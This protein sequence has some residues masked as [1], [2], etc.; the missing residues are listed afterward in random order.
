MTAEPTTVFKLLVAAV[1]SAPSAPFLIDAASGEER[2]YQTVLDSALAWAAWFS[3]HNVRE[4]IAVA[5]PNSAAFVE[6]SLGAALRGITLLAFNPALPPSELSAQLRH[7]RAERLFTTARH[8]PTLSD[9]PCPVVCV[10]ER[11]PQPLPPPLALG[12]LAPVAADTALTAV[13]TSGTSGHP[14]TALV[15]HR[16]A[17]WSALRTREAFG[18][19]PNTRYLTPLPLFHINAQ[20]VAVLTALAATSAVALSPRLPAAQLFEAVQ[21][22]RAQGLSL[23]P[24]LV[25]DLLRQEGSFGPLLRYAAGGMRR[26]RRA[27]RATTRALGS[28][29][30]GRRSR[31]HAGRRGSSG[32][33]RSAPD[34]HRCHQTS[35]SRRQCRGS[36]AGGRRRGR[37]GPGHDGSAQSAR[38]SSSAAD[39]EPSASGRAPTW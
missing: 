13:L 2:S 39:V 6:L 30:S 33:R 23:V 1:E 19:E 3:E 37:S 16:G 31:W 38:C 14:R 11:T 24:A 25:Y 35:R 22:T 10:G 8:A 17:V 5:L 12:S 26:D 15:S 36:W 18:I 9:P 29:T 20:V 34:R 27:G 32:H 4:R 21:R 28:S 7:R